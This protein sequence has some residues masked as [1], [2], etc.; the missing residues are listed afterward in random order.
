MAH[1]ALIIDDEADIREL[2]A[3]SLDRIGLDT[4]TAS[5]LE[6][7]RNLLANYTFD[8]CLTDMK[9]PDGNGVEFVKHVQEVQPKLPVAVITAHGNMDAAVDAMKNGAFDFVSKPVDLKLLRNLVTQAINLDNDSATVATPD[10]VE[11]I[12]VT[13]LQPISMNK[14]DHHKTQEPPPNRKRIN[15]LD[16]LVKKNANAS[17]GR[18]SSESEQIK[19]IGQER[20]IGHSEPMQA[21]KTMILKV[22]R[23]NAPVWITGESGT[24]KELIARLIH[25]N[26]PRANAPFVAVNCGAI[27]SE[28]MESEM[29]GHRKGSFTGAHS[30]HDGLFKQAEGGTLFLDEVAEQPL[31]MQ[32]KLLRA[33]QE[34]KVRP[35][36]SSTEIGTNVRI[37]S[38][39]HKDLATEVDDGHFRHDLYYRLNV[40]CIRSPSLRQRRDDVVIIARHVLKTIAQ[41]EGRSLT[42]LLTP[43]AENL[44]SAYSFPGNVRELENILE[45][46]VA[47]SDNDQIEP[48]DLNLSPNNQDQTTETRRPT[49]ETTSEPEERQT[50][51]DTLA[52][53][54]WNRRASAE[55]LGLSYR[56]LRY[57]IKQY[58]IDDDK[59]T[60][61]DS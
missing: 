12:E 15:K 57:R 21:L 44:L 18:M 28:L 45:R 8:V 46:A 49:T 40:I 3:M 51:L 9:L 35:V 42:A 52:E 4:H 34:R 19:L 41:T 56:Q 24:G 13:T 31:H 43:E 25:D 14:A 60:G 39:S 48:A 16:D 59:K 23:T 10:T 38:A 29:F 50:I 54:R 53:T 22:A 2:I 20:L 58:G 47:L 1:T 26:S 32:V 61:T 6:E 7:A 55:K 33:I 37:L 30:D 27:P 11:N 17:E 5:N 36:G